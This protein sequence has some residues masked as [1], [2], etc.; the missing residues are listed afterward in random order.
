MSVSALFLMGS[1]AIFLLGTFQ[2]FLA[3]T[4][5]IR[6]PMDAPLAAMARLQYLF[7][8]IAVFGLGALAYLPRERAATRHEPLARLGFWLMFLGFNLALFP[9]R[10]RRSPAFVSDPLTLLSTGVGPEVPLG[11]VLFLA[12]TALCIGAGARLT[13]WTRS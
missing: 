3:Q 8:G 4:L 11:V 1:M 13:G 9:T 7:W 2:G 5:P 6:M 12:G 10:L